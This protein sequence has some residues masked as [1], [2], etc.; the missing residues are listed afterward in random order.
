MT[1]LTAR[2]FYKQQG[3]NPGFGHKVKSA[4]RLVTVIEDGKER[5]DVE[6]SI[7]RYNATMDPAKSHMAAVNAAQREKHRGVGSTP[8]GGIPGVPPAGADT[9][10]KNATYMQAKT[11][12]EVY[13]AKSAQLDYEE[14]SGKLIQMTAVESVFGQGLAATRESLMQ[15]PS[16]EAAALAAETDAQKVEK[17]LADAIH[18]ALTSLAAPLEKLTKPAA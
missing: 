6:Q 8:A 9:Q 17:H 15:I 18:A 7:E 16:R 4:G 5:I 2:A 1:T 10:S 12:R 13:E 3:W 14:R 11:A